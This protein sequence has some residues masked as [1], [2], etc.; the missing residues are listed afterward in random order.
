MN[1]PEQH[2]GSTATHT[3]NPTVSVVVIGRNEGKRLTACLASVHDAR[4]QNLNYELIYVDSNSTDDSV[5]SA[6]ASGAQVLQ[7][8]PLRPSAATG[9]NAGW[10]A[11]Q[12]DFVLFL[13]GDTMLHP[14]FVTRALASMQDRVAIVW[15]HRRERA[16]QDSFYNRILDLDWV[17]QPG[18]TAFCGG[19]ALMRR[20][21]LA[22][23]GGFDE[24]LI[25]GEEP[26]LCRRLRAKGYT[27]Q[28]PDIPM[29]TH[30]LAI[31]RF[32]AYWKRATRAGHAY[33]EI[34]RR[35]ADSGD[36]FWLR[37]SRQNL[38]HGTAMMVGAVVLLLTLM[39]SLQAGLWAL[40][41]AGL[42]AG[43]MVV[44][45]MKRNAWKSSDSVTL[46]LYAVHS[47]FQQIPIM[48]G[49]LLQ[50]RDSRQGRKRALIEY[51]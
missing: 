11:A 35:F 4:W 22:E 31:R 32:G 15:G 9:R 46:A 43:L 41:G 2:L 47:H 25:A 48:I 24:A 13:D 21:V 49:Q 26:E 36:R 37:E 33:A 38:I 10:R 7:V 20:A 42:L 1:S 44:R 12:G 40:A 18:E 17:Y 45:T 51:K 27:I 30:D 14:D 28:H 16:V 29:T 23:V 6:K 8:K 19:D 34:S 3:A 5:A 50:S 39:V